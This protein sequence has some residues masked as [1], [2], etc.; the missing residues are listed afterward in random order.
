MEI[1]Q[2]I[3]KTTPIRI[4]TP[5]GKDANKCSGRMVGRGLRQRIRK[6]DYR[7]SKFVQLCSAPN[8]FRHN[9]GV[10]MRLSIKMTWNSYCFSYL[11]VARKE[12]QVW[13][14]QPQ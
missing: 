11:S 7:P 1:I 10:L 5:F 12:I 3:G 9:L 6:N 2:R 13:K 8:A 4:M 14:Q